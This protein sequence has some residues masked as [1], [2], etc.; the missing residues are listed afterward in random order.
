MGLLDI[1][2]VAII[3][4]HHRCCSTVIHTHITQLELRKESWGL[5]LFFQAHVTQI[6]YSRPFLQK[7][8]AAASEGNMYVV[9][10]VVVVIGESGET[11]FSRPLAA[12]C[13]LAA[14]K[15]LGSSHHS[16]FLLLLRLI[17][18]TTLHCVDAS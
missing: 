3:V 5:C 14:D 12:I 11:I 8:A 18:P 4:H 10:V 15:A 1:A 6:V 13:G 17:F 16:T 7:L 9:V 2:I